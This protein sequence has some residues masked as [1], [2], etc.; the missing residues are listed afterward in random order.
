MH[1]LAPPD[2]QLHFL[3]GY[4]L[5]M[6][7]PVGR[8]KISQ[9]QPIYIISRKSVVVPFHNAYNRIMHGYHYIRQ[10]KR[11]PPSRTVSTVSP[12]NDTSQ[13]HETQ[14]DAHNSSVNTVVDLSNAFM[15]IQSRSSAGSVRTN[16]SSPWP[17]I[18]SGCELSVFPN[19]A[20]FVEQTKQRTEII[21]AKADC[22]II[23]E[24]RG[25]VK[26]PVLERMGHTVT[27]TLTPVLYAPE[28]DIPLLSVD[29][30]NKQGFHVIFVPTYA[31]IF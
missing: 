24:I 14:F 4:A 29:S 7:M 3:K 19:L 13:D 6:D 5:S 23:S 30:L 27:I 11:Q 31:G 17:M 26:L 9:D 1:D 12:L 28:C 18:D 21:T 25:T 2:N 16:T 10:T 22:S 8:I 15:Y 20:L